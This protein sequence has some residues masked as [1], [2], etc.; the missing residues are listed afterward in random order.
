MELNRLSLRSD[1]A[2]IRMNLLVQ[3]VQAVVL[4]DTTAT[5]LMCTYKQS[6]ELDTNVQEKI[7]SE[8][9]GAKVSK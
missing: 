5:I 2:P 4:Q 9:K 1:F 7:F 8:N 3:I 6:F